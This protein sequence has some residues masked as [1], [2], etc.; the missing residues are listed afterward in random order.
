MGWKVHPPSGRHTS[1]MGFA[2]PFSFLS[3]SLESPRV[4]F[5]GLLVSP[6]H[7]LGQEAAATQPAGEG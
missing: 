2:F 5:A 4:F 7:A 1:P 3:S 6:H